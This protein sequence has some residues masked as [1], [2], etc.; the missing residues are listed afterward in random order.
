[1]PLH[2]DGAWVLLDVAKEACEA[3]DAQIRGV[4]IWWISIDL[5]KQ[6]QTSNDQ[7]RDL[8]LPLLSFLTVTKPSS[9]QQNTVM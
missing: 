3:D 2:C 9:K 8:A 6:Y 7:H 4:A 5:S 1:M